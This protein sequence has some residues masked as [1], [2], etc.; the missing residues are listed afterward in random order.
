MV[1]RTIQEQII[2]EA[3]E[4]E[5]LKLGLLQSGKSLADIPIQLPEQQIADFSA[6]QQAA[7]DRAQAEGG[8]GAISHT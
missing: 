3:P 4:I 2:R 8:I 5:A 1:E 7:F 6:L